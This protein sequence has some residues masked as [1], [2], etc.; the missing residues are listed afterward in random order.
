MKISSNFYASKIF[1][2]HPVAIYSLDDRVDYISLISDEQR[3]FDSGGW[4]VI[5]GTPED[6]PSL[7]DLGSPFEDNLYSSIVGDV[8]DQ[9]GF[10][11]EWESPELFS[12]EDLDRKIG[13]FAMSMFLYQDSIYVNYY[14]VGYRFFDE[15]LQIDREFKTRFIAKDEK[16]WINFNFSYLPPTFNNSRVRIFVQ[17]NTRPGGETSEE[18][19]FIVNG[20]SVG[21]NA[22]Q[23][24]FASLGASVVQSPIPEISG[25][26]S[27]QYGIEEKPGYHV[28]EGGTKI[29]AR[30]YGIPM[31]FGSD[32]CTTLFPSS[33]EGDPSIIFPSYG[34][35]NDSGRYQDYTAEFWMRIF[36]NTVEEKRIF[37]PLN[38]DYGIYVTNNVMSLLI[39]NSFQS[40]AVSEWYRPMLVHLILKD[41]VAQLLVNG[42]TV[43]S[44]NYDRGSLDYSQE[45][46]LGFFSYD[47]FK[48]FEID[49]FS[50]YSYPVPEL[51][52][53]K[54]FVWGQGVDF[55]ENIAKSFSGNSAFVNFSSANY[56]SN[57]TYPDT[58][59]W[60]AGYNENLLS[61]RSSISAPEY[62]LPQ[63]FIEDREKEEL[64]ESNK[65]FLE[66][67]DDLFFTFRPNVELDVSGEP[68]ESWTE[69][70][71]LKYD[72]LSFL[73]NL[74]AFYGVFASKDVVTEQVLAMFINSKTQNKITIKILDGKV[75]YFYNDEV[76]NESTLEEIPFNN[77]S[78]GSGEN[79]YDYPYPGPSPEDIKA[80]V[81]GIDIIKFSEFFNFPISNFFQ[82]TESIQVYIGGDGQ[83][84][85]RDRIYK[86]GFVARENYPE[87][88]DYFD[89]NGFVDIS[90]YEF[91]VNH[92]A[93]YT[94]TPLIRF[95]RFFLDISISSRW[96]EY[97]PLTMFSSFKR[98]NFGKSFYDLDYLQL[99][100]GYSSRTE[101]IE[102]ILDGLGW[103][104]Q[105]L[106]NEYNVPVQRSYEILDNAILTGYDDYDDLAANRQVERFLSAE[107]SGVRAFLTFQL[108]SEGANRP[109]SQFPLRK[110][111]SEERF[112]D[113]NQEGDSAN[114]FK[115]YRTA[116]E[117]LDKTVVYP[118]RS[119]DIQQV[120]IVIHFEM[121]QEG[122]LSNPLKIRDLEI[123]SKA[124]DSNV[125]EPIGTDSGVELY[126]YVRSGVYFDKNQQNPVLI[127]KQNLPYL[128]LTSDSGIKVL[129]R[130]D[131]SREFG[132]FVP[133]NET[134][135][136]EYL[137]GAMQIWM[138]Y[139]YD[140]FAPVFYPI[141]EIEAKNKTVEVVVRSN[142]SG[143]KGFV[144]ARN[145]KTR[146]P[147]N[148]LTFYQNGILVK[149]PV[150]DIGQWT[151][152]GISFEDPLDFDEYS[153]SINVFRGITF[154][155]VAHFEAKGLNQTS[156]AIVRQWR[157]V[158]RDDFDVVVDWEY[159]YDKDINEILR[160]WRGVL[161]ISDFR[162]FAITPSDIYKTYIG[163]NRIVV[164]DNSGISL[165]TDSFLVFSD[166][167]WSRE[168]QKPL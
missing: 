33:Q 53:K 136:D 151:S 69:Q 82:S 126:P 118:P 133:V 6:D 84:T 64:F 138:K 97:F 168:E 35:M 10:I 67:R 164:D 87:V 143:E 39:G 108:L 141:F 31:V 75:V 91:F 37:G 81:V 145:K 1:S 106:F 63:V 113:A 85:F 44:I 54:R 89:Q 12:L 34:M 162:F 40:Y 49:C 119:V 17:A 110:N 127:S 149:N 165:S 41:G 155:N 23:T 13:S 142:E 68:G 22:E 83:N 128:Y 43:I 86:F 116:F 15:F 107:Q 8:P 129:G 56:T 38:S 80:Y 2:E 9:N 26:R 16:S 45:E 24:S 90:E 47:D 100:F 27:S 152:I 73:N 109:L 5:N 140:E 115:A 94:L 29:L 154:N 148:G 51:V 62:P 114:P 4:N 59:N 57:K 20:I 117:F 137:M 124:L 125:F 160:T 96:E 50:L 147:E 25:I 95:N 3:L 120:A 150:I 159:W 144:F 102:R 101:I 60:R 163:V 72:S 103:T 121:K 36:P 18:Y 79:S 146:L 70:G 104:Y 93:T 19:T 30:N 32:N 14:E 76:I 77:Y 61:T 123:A 99:N 131:T 157:S 55:S 58:L 98:N 92:F 122:I 42:E 105:E 156:S 65:Q 88:K 112:I 28:V 132:I 74:S 167:I 130:R 153:G 161:V 66:N 78:T 71:Y 166:V 46:W 48:I 11:I 52:A 135:K 139:D 134:R 21:Q 158:W 7:P 111:M